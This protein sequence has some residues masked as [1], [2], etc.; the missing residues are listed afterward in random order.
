MMIERCI[1]DWWQVRSWRLGGINSHHWCG[2][3]TNYIQLHKRRYHNH[4]SSKFNT[5]IVIVTAYIHKG[6]TLE[7]KEFPSLKQGETCVYTLNGLLKVV[8]VDECPDFFLNFLTECF[9]QEGAVVDMR[10]H[11]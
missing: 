1:V 5:Y 4:G 7:K 2:F 11:L 3:V 10:V 6:T 9:N 8:L